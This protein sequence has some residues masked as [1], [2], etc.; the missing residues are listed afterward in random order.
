M[1]VGALLGGGLLKGGIGDLL[2]PQKLISNLTADYH[3]DNLFIEHRDRAF[4]AL[5]AAGYPKAVWNSYI[6]KFKINHANIEDRKIGSTY[7]PEFQSLED[8]VRTFL[9]TQTGNLGNYFAEINR[10]LGKKRQDGEAYKGDVAEAIR[11]AV[12]TF[13]DGYKFGGST[14]TAKSN[15]N[16][17]TG[18]GGLFDNFG[19]NFDAGDIGDVLGGLGGTKEKKQMMVVKVVGITLAIAAVIGTIIYFVVR[20]KRK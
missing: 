10:D 5:E 20:K 3:Q 17:N 1:L 16:M 6:E 19:G 12:S 7:A 2:N 8:M 4:D 14:T 18:I 13:P 15:Q 9:N 11:Y